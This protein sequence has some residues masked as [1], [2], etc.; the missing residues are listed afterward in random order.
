MRV[1]KTNRPKAVLISDIHFSLKNLEPASNVLK[2][3]IFRAEASQIPLIIAGDL[4]DT[5]ALIRAEVANRL[6]QIV[7]GAEIPIYLIVGNH[8]LVNEK[9]KEHALNYLSP[10]VS[11]VSSIVEVEGLTL[12]PYMSDVSALETS[13][14]KFRKGSILVMHQGFLGAQMG[15][16][17]KDDSSI[18]PEL[19]KD[20]TVISGHYHKHQQ[21]GTVT[22]IGSPYTITF[23]EA[24]DGPKGFLVLNEDGSY[25]RV[26]TNLRKHII[27][28]RTLDTLHDSIHDLKDDDLVWIK[29]RGLRSELESLDRNHIKTSLKIKGYFKLDLISEDREVPKITIDDLNP[30]EILDQLIASMTESDTFKEQLRDAWKRI[31]K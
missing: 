27:V 3:A 31:L 21:I 11:L 30:G 26:Y 15:E 23:T 20:F 17:V 10:Y 18:N 5:K 7:S 4:Q 28:D 1:K 12:I 14:S 8:D 19:F 29:L 24:H 6:L 13:L 22:Y 25:E 16:Y 2:Q 9:G